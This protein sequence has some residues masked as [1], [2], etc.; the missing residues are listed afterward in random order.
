MNTL[1]EA[2]ESGIV[3][4][5][6]DEAFDDETGAESK[7]GAEASVSTIGLPSQDGSATVAVSNIEAGGAKDVSIVSPVGAVPEAGG[8]GTV[9]GGGEEDG[10]AYESSEDDEDRNHKHRRRA[11][12]ARLARERIE[13]GE[14]RASGGGENALT[15]KRPL[16]DADRAPRQNFGR[17]LQ[18]SRR[19]LQPANHNIR[20]RDGGRTRFGPLDGGPLGMQ[21]RV[22][23]AFRGDERDRFENDRGNMMPGTAGAGGNGWAPFDRFGGPLPPFLDGPS[24]RVGPGAYF[25]GRG[26]GAPFRGP[27][28]GPRGPPGAPGS[29][30]EF[31]P[32]GGAHGD[33]PIGPGMPGVGPGMSAMMGR[34]VAGGA[35]PQRCPDFDNQ[36]FCLKGDTCPLDHGADRIVLEDIQVPYPYACHLSCCAPPAHKP[37]R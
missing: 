37:N 12:G 16:P 26:A 7:G 34:V 6:D 30:N 31:G 1:F 10:V 29:W 24:P 4:L 8:V 19:S 20:N 9:G 23:V 21:R 15:K 22:G 33:V 14:M 25:P 18:D 27:M 17:Q 13:E 2:L 32:G 11:A 28:Q 5:E 35:R 3:Q 36:G